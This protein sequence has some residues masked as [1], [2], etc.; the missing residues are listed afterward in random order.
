[1]S[2][3]AFAPLVVIF[4]LIKYRALKGQHLNP[5][6]SWYHS[7]QSPLASSERRLAA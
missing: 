7:G 4:A 3:I 5:R 1:M 2:T 6:L